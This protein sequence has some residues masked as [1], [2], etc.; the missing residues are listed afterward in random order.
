MDKDDLDEDDSD[1]DD[2]D[3]DSLT[4]G[5]MRNGLTNTAGCKDVFAGTV[6]DAGDAGGADA[7]DA[8]GAANEGR[9]IRAEVV[10]DGSC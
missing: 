8:G 3:D 10:G 7:G 4:G 5:I 9:A 2:S 6:T 1:E